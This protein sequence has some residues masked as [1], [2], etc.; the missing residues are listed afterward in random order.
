M[1]DCQRRPLIRKYDAN[2][3]RTPQVQQQPQPG[4]ARKHKRRREY[5]TEGVY[6]H[7][8]VCILTIHMRHTHVP[9]HTRMHAHAREHRGPA[10]GALPLVLAKVR[11]RGLGFKYQGF[12][13]LPLV[14]CRCWQK[15]LGSFVVTCSSLC[16]T[17]HN[18][19]PRTHICVYAD[20]SLPPSLPPSI[21]L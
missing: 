11:D 6:V 13:L 14:F 17:M 19:L 1:F 4:S 21:R 9:K 8:C 7:V 15:I 12:G 5:D 2:S 18:T 20:M 3:A 10:G 16:D